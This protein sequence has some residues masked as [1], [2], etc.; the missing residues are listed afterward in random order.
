[1]THEQSRYI[2]KIAITLNKEHHFL[3]CLGDTSIKHISHVIYH[4]PDMVYDILDDEFKD[5]FLEINYASSSDIDKVY[6]TYCLGQL[7]SLF[8]HPKMAKV[9]YNVYYREV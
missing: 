2:A 1:M 4:C 6:Y 5:S 9:F 3:E 8:K 7:C